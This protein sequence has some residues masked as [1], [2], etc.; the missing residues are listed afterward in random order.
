MWMDLFLELTKLMCLLECVTSAPIFET[1]IKDVQ[2]YLTAF[3]YL[4][5]ASSSRKS[6]LLDKSGFVSALRQLQKFAGLEETGVVDDKTL[7]ILKVP[8]CSLPDIIEHQQ[9]YYPKPRKKR[10]A[11]QGSRWRKKILS[12]KVGK[13]PTGLD[14]VDVDTDVKRAFKMW[15]DASGLTFLNKQLSDDPVDIEIRFENYYHGDEDSFDGPGGE[16]QTILFI[17]IFINLSGHVA[18]AFFPEFGGDAHFDNK[19]Y[20]TVNKFTVRSWFFKVDCNVSI[21]QGTNLLQSVT[22][23]IGH[24][25]GLQHFN[26]TDSMMAPFYKGWDP[27]MKLSKD[28]ITAVKELYNDIVSVKEERRWRYF[29]L[30]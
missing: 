5:K 28:D 15:S 27:F 10:Y 1:Q 2:N 7:E 26:K 24:S 19:E 21:L 12:Y 16:D 3:G 14:K 17:R 20:W 13:Y 6:F 30:G 18:H 11:V 23:E 29:S 8:R 4:P 9:D 22:H 25:L